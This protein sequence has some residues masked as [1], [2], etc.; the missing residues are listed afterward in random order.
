MMQTMLSKVFPKS[1]N[2]L[3]LNNNAN[4][5]SNRGYLRSRIIIHNVDIVD[6]PLEYFKNKIPQF[7]EEMITRQFIFP[8]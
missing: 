7:C 5:T 8:T 3:A 2:T 4:K 6:K 1:A